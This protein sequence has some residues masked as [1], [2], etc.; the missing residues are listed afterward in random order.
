[1]FRC[2]Q[3]FWLGV[4]VERRMRMRARMEIDAEISR[5]WAEACDWPRGDEGQTLHGRQTRGRRRDGGTAERNGTEQKGR[6]AEAGWL[7]GVCWWMVNDGGGRFQASQPSDN[8][9]L[10]G[11]APHGVVERATLVPMPCISQHSYGPI[12]DDAHRHS[13]PTRQS[14][15]CCCGLLTPDVATSVESRASVPAPAT[16][17][18]A[19]P[20]ST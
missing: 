8:V 15:P 19:R 17:Q 6:V 13:P 4:W 14:S 1:M 2:V 11:D 10:M 5:D 7:R 3:M 18:D 9:G 12:L 20:L 16:R